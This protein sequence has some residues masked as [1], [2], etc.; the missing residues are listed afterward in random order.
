MAKA[1][2][3]PQAKKAEIKVKLSKPMDFNEAM[4]RIVRVK[5][6]SSDK[7]NDIC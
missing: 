7:P 6:P 1:K 5:P 4:Q 2:K 3:K